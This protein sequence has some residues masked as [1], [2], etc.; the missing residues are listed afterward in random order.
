MVG[1]WVQ[2][3]SE[4]VQP[5]ILAIQHRWTRSLRRTC[6]HVHRRWVAGLHY[7][8][9]QLAYLTERRRICRDTLHDTRHMTLRRRELR[10]ENFLE[11]AAKSSSTARVL[12]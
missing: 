5:L 8:S 11:F 7:W 1:L 6:L 12:S 2:G 4:I 10:A 3:E 9:T